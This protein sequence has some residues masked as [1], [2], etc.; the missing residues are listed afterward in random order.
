MKRVNSLDESKSIRLRNQN[1]HACRTESRVDLAV[2]LLLLISL[3]CVPGCKP[4]PTPPSVTPA[5]PS[6]TPSPPDTIV[7]SGRRS[8]AGHLSADRVLHDFGK[9]DQNQKLVTSFE[10]TNDGKETLKIGKLIPSCKCVLAPLKT[11]VLEPDQSV[12]LQVTFTT[13]TRPGKAIQTVRIPTLPPALPSVL[14]VRLIAEVK[15]YITVEPQRFEI[16]LSK[17]KQ[18]DITLKISSDDSKPF[19]IL[20]A[21]CPDKAIQLGFDKSKNASTHT[22]TLK[23]DR[24]SLNTKQ[25]NGLITLRLSHPKSRSTTIGYHIIPPYAAFPSTKLF[26]DARPGKKVTGFISIVSN[27]KEPFELGE[28]HSDN[29]L[30]RVKNIEKIMNEYKLEIEMQIP[31]NPKQK[32]VYDTLNVQI[33]DDPDNSLK[34]NCYAVL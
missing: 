34:I 28:I 18:P 27:F 30:V 14:A 25:T 15:R 6:S 13:S 33:K 5:E 23:V 2:L 17:E 7:P 12:T 3:L 20:S 16:K 11:K 26:S 4:K 10:L 1:H 9:V 31:E 21:Q 22:I 19:R 32:T 29:G 8:D 24:S